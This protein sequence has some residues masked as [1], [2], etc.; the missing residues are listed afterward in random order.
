MK[1]YISFVIVL[2]RRLRAR[3]TQSMIGNVEYR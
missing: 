2:Q 1:F 3:K